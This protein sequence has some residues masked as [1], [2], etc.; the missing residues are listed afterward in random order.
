MRTIKLFLILFFMSMFSLTI[1]AE[2]EEREFITHVPKTYTSKKAVP[3][4]LVL[5]GYTIDADTIEEISGLSDLSEKEGFIAVYPNGTKG[6]EKKRGWNCGGSY[7]GKIFKKA[8]DEAYLL[9]LVSEIRGKYS[10]DPNQVYIIGYNNGGFMAHVMAEHHP[11]IFA[12]IGVVA[13][14]T[15]MKLDEMKT[16]V[17]VIHIHG[18]NDA[19][20]PI[21]GNDK[22]ASLYDLMEKVRVLDACGKETVVMKTD[23]VSGLLWK[24]KTHDAAMYVV[25]DLGNEWPS[26]ELDTAKVLWDFLKAHPKK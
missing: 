18:M 9:S 11:D 24:G 26:N 10:I 22:I 8:K 21:G 2:T 16:P 6:S 13:A 17:S 23:A 5:H 7:Y 15:Y 12:S 14:S 3:L 4:V 25:D 1:F 19:I 20:V